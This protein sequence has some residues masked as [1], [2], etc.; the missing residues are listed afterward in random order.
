MRS[1]VL[2][3]AAGSQGFVG[4]SVFLIVALVFLCCCEHLNAHHSLHA[5]IWFPLLLIPDYTRG[6]YDRAQ[7]YAPDPTARHVF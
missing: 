2:H 5:V 3:R 7:L 1:Q 4:Q 6:P